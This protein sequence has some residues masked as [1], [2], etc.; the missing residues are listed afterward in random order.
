VKAFHEPA[1]ATLTRSYPEHPTLVD[2]QLVG[3][4][5]LNLEA[6]AGL[7]ARM[8]AADVEYNR[9]DIPVGVDPAHTPANGLS[10]EETIRRIEDCGSWMVLKSIEQDEA[11]RALLHDV[12][13][14][15]EPAVHEATGAMLKREGFLF[16]SSPG[17]VTPFHFDP[18][19]NILLQIRGSKT[20]TIFPADDEG[21]V[22]GAEHERFHTGGHRN[23]PWQEAFAERGKP[24]QLTPGK[25]VYVPVKA[26]HWVKNGP[27]VS[28]S[29][30]ITWRSQWSYREESARRLNHLLR[31][32]GVTPRA[33][34]RWPHQNHAKSLGFK[35]ADKA[36]IGRS[37][38]S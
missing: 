27:E 5:L 19:H 34:R 14:A 21:L 37:R 30:S 20:M 2:H 25:A 36:G 26:P 9:G 31:R 38:T 12:L 1:L 4:E 18:E 10:I 3:H 22:S 7:A 8:R 23:L 24:F 16:I 15:V 29:L 33:P 28:I 17:A 35:L 32:A 11:Y 13:A 6:V